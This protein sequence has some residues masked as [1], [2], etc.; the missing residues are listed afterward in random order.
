[1]VQTF[2]VRARQRCVG[3][4]VNLFF[5]EDDED[6]GACELR[7]VTVEGVCLH[8]CLLDDDE[9]ILYAERCDPVELVKSLRALDCSWLWCEL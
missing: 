2:V 1:M 9:Q 5:W 4:P 3:T 7:V 8:M 6:G